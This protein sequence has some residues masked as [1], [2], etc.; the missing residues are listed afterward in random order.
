[1]QVRFEWK[2][3]HLTY[4]MEAVP[5]VGDAVEVEGRVGIVTSVGWV[6]DPMQKIAVVRVG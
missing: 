6:V 1:M 2:D 4:E 3:R 5:R